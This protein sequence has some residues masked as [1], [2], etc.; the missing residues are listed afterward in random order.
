MRFNQELDIHYDATNYPD[1]VK[2]HASLL[3][4][5]ISVSL[6][7]V[8]ILTLFTVVFAIGWPMVA[9]SSVIRRL[10]GSIISALAP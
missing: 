6:G 9:A 8:A 7:T 5:L 10:K 1:D 2:E 3:L 4:I